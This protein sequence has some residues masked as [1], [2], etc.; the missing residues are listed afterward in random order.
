MRGVG[1]R[2]VEPADAVPSSRS[3]VRRRLLISYLSITL[4][5]LL[6]LEIPLGLRVRAVRAAAADDAVQHDALALSIRAEDAL[7]SGDLPAACSASSTTT[8][9]TPAAASS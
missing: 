7:E 1:F 4:F 3:R 8:S 9:A 5:V 2:L 6:V